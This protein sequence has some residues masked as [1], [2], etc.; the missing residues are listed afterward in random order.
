MRSVTNMV[1]SMRRV[2][3]AMAIRSFLTAA[4]PS[5]SG[6]STSAAANSFQPATADFMGYCDP[7]WVS[8]YTYTALFNRI[9]AVNG[10]SWHYDPNDLD[11]SYER[12]RIDEEGATWTKPIDLHLPPSGKPASVTL[13]DGGRHEV[14]AGRFYPYSHLPGGV[15]LFPKQPR[16]VTS[17]SFDIEGLTRLVVRHAVE[18]QTDPPGD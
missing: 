9:S 2:R 11:Q 8:D 14:V 18:M 5:E 3:S 1:A 13:E 16:S 6:D 12:I 17:A 4:E 15:L 7:T 10:A